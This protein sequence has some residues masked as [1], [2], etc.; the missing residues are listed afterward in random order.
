MPKKRVFVD[1]DV[2]LECFRIKVWSELTQRC[3]VETIR[4][5]YDEALAG[6]SLAAGYI[7]ASAA[8]QE[9]GCHAGYHRAG[10]VDDGGRGRGVYA[11]VHR[12]H[13]VDVSPKRLVRKQT[14][15]TQLDG[16][17]QCCA[18][19]AQHQGRAQR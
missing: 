3:Q 14:R 12:A 8:E 10:G 15:R 7:Q 1:T 2:I 5:C 18:L 13:Q 9:K 17:G 6:N 16:T 11:H 4:T 19:A